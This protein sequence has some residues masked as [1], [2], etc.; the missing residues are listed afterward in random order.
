MNFVFYDTETT[1]ADVRYDQVLQSA[2]ILTDCR[3]REIET[4]SLRCRRLPHIVPRPEAL[5]VTQIDPF[6]METAELSHFD[7]IKRVHET[8]SRWSP[9]VFIGYNTLQFDEEILRHEFW[10]NLLDP[11]VTSRKGNLRADVI[12]MARAA[13]AA[14]PSVLEIPINP[15]TGHPIYRLETIAPLNGFEG[16]DAH[17]ALGD[18]RATIFIARLIMDRAPEVWQQMLDNAETRRVSDML[19]H[20]E[21][22][23]L[24]HF[25][26]PHVHRVLHIG[27]NPEN[28]K[29]VCLF[30]LANDP[31]P[32]LDQ[33]AEQ[34]F[35]TMK[36]DFR[37][38]REVKLNAQPA[39][40][41][42]DQPFAPQPTIQID[43]AIVRERIHAIR[44]ANGFFERIGQALL[45]RQRAF[46]PGKF[47]EDRLYEGFSSWAD[48]GLTEN[49]Q[50]TSRWSDRL[51]LVRKFEDGRLS[52]LGKRLVYFV[53]PDAYD[54]ETQ[55]AFEHTLICR[56][57]MAADPETPWTTL[58]IAIQ[59]L[60][61]FANG[62]IKDRIVQWF[63]AFSRSIDA[64]ILPAGHRG[65][66]LQPLARTCPDA[67][68]V[69]A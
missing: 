34:M 55:A 57:I 42:P 24:S 62:P 6:S 40:F 16:H 32:Y 68:C 12:Q 48:K 8:F 47:V 4:I 69:P 28:D 37:I 56:R 21:I 61:K 49:F 45:M 7:M 43:E 27:T 64:G 31:A 60:D 20:G 1:G 41:R 51:N 36:T 54:A 52:T 23:L 38:L 35:E 2:A 30:D 44:T 17:D 46:P 65:I 19:D 59:A 3:L 13:V 50:Q 29:K 9:A 15:A 67:E 10:K 58:P 26:E 5:A 66:P 14:D 25:G 63:D 33:T 11:Y 22:R 18:V 39:L 53:A